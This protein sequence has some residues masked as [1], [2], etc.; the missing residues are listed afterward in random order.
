MFLHCNINQSYKNFSQSCIQQQKK[1][2]LIKIAHK[3]TF[4]PG[5]GQFRKAG[6]Y[7]KTVVN[8]I[9][10]FKVW[11]LLIKIDMEGACKF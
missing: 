3:H 2:V 9:F 6:E 8:S 11:I 10:Y 1:S 5:F 7:L 4:S